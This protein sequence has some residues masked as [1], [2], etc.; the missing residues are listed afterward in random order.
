MLILRR[1]LPILLGLLYVV[2]PVDV[3]PDFLPALG[4]LDDLLLMGVLVWFLVRQARGQSPWDFLRGRARGPYTR[5]PGGPGP[6]DLRADFAQ[7][8]PYTLLE[9]SPSA[10]PE[11][12]KSAYKRAVARYHPDKV[13]HLG[14]EFRELAHRKLVAIQQAYESL[15]GKG[16]R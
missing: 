9:V 16:R 10:T 1:W 4:W 2:S 11:E 5:Y 8:D 12:I 14:A 3:L 15:Q 13:S 7:M 6:E